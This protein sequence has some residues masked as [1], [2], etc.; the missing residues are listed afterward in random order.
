MLFNGRALDV[1]L[2]IVMSLIC[3]FYMTIGYKLNL[4]LA[5]Y[6]EGRYVNQRNSV[7]Y[8]RWTIGVGCGLIALKSII[9]S[10]SGVR[11]YYDN[12]A[13]ESNTWLISIYVLFVITPIEAY[14]V[15]SLLVSFR[16]GYKDRWGALLALELAPNEPPPQ[17]LLVP[18]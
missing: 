18:L 7:Y 3:I 6:Y 15:I 5:C 11:D 10:I 8:Y 2:A 12:L 14:A 4:N 17:N 9:E 16:A 1:T 13:G